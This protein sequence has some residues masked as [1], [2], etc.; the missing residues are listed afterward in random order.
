VTE[1]TDIVMSPLWVESNFP[2]EIMGWVSEY[3][4]M[5]FISAIVGERKKRRRKGI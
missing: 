3:M 1:K 4:S 2:K 5:D